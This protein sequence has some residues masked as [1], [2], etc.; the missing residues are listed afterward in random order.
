MSD[1][2][3]LPRYIVVLN[4]AMIVILL[5][6]CALIFAL[7]L[8]SKEL[9]WALPTADSQSSAVS[10]TVGEASSADVQASESE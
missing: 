1:R 5:A 8:S 7:T 3:K 10:Q 4:I 9:G 6:I 2:Q